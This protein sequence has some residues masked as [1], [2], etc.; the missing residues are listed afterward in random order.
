M[1]STVPGGAYLDDQGRPQ[2][3]NG[4]RLKPLPDTLSDAEKKACREAGLVSQKQAEHFGLEELQERFGLEETLTRKAKGEQVDVDATAKA[5]E[6]AEEA[7][8]NLS[9]VEG[10]GKDGR[11]TK[12]DVEAAMEPNDE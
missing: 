7:D 1:A 9:E 3:A 4:N 5:A 6:L 12:S 10:T 11:I 2:D 8:L